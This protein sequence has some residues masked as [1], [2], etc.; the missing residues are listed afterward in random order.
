MGALCAASVIA[1]SDKGGVVGRSGFAFG[2][3]A[4]LCFADILSEHRPDFLSGSWPR[5]GFDRA[6]IIAIGA[7]Q[8]FGAG[9][10]FGLGFRLWTICQ[11]HG[12]DWRSV[13]G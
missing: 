12:V 13:F 10:A 11:R 8:G 5:A 9:G 7:P 1:P 3:S 4:F 6:R 2:L